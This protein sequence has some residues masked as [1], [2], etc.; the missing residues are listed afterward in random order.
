MPNHG[1]STN[2]GIQVYGFGGIAIGLVGLVGG[3]FAYVWQPIQSLGD[4]PHRVALTYVVTACG[5]AVQWRRTTPVGIA[6]L[7]ALHLISALL[8]LPRVVGFPNI[9]GTWAGFLQQFSMV[10]SGMVAYQS[11][12]SR[13]ALWTD[14]ISQIGR[15]LYGICVISYGVAHFTAIS[16]TARMVPEWIPPGQTLWA[17]A[18]G[19]F[20][21]LAAIVG[22][23]MLI[24]YSSRIAANAGITR[25]ELRLAAVFG[26]LTTDFQIDRQTV[27]SVLA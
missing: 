10:A 19:V 18:T 2:L 11:L 24:R 13:R 20:D 15:F 4:V 9:Y 17:I 16:Q 8:W 26:W 1:P 25:T 6:I 3:D 12:A 7:S 23:C 14:R 27:I 22:L 21:L 5:L